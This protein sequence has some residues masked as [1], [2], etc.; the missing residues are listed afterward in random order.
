MEYTEEKIYKAEAETDS[1]IIYL[2]GDSSCMGYREHVKKLLPDYNVVYPEENA[3]C[4][5]YMLIM[6]RGW[7]GLV[8]SEKVKLVQFNTGHWDIAHWNDEEISLNSIETYTENMLRIAKTL[9]RLYPNAKIVYATTMPMNPNGENS[10][11]FRYTSEIKEYNKAA[12][13]ALEREGVIIND[14]FSFAESFTPSDYA[15]Y[16]H[17]TDEANARVAKHIAE[18]FSNIL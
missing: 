18:F 8:K 3:R 7:G 4:S 13:N 12:V 16:C 17:L 6:L 14:L 15:D 10:I 1:D 11:N 9:K 5:Q 2:L